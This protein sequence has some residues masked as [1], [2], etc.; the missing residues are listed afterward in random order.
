MKSN[1]WI[2]ILDYGSQYSQLIA[3]RVREQHVYSEM[4]RFD[5]DAATLAKRKPAGIILSG[6][7]S[8]VFQD[9]APMGDPKL[10]DIGVPV[11]GICYGMQMT[12]KILG[13]HVRPG[14]EREYGH[15][16]IARQGISSLF[17][18]LPDTINVWMSHGDQ[19]ERL[20]EGFRVA[21]STSTC[22]VAAMVSADDRIFGLQF[23]PEVAHTQH[24]ADILKRFVFDVCG[25]RGEW[26]MSQ[27]VEE[28]IRDIRAKVG[29]KHVIC[30]LS[31]GVDSSVV[32]LLLHKAIGDQLHCIFVDNGVLRHGE[33]EQVEDTF[34]SAF[35][36]DLHVAHA[37]D[38][39]LRK[40]KGVVDPETK[41]KIIGNTF[42]DVFSE[43]ARR[44]GDIDFLAQGT[45]YPDVIESLSPLGGP[46][47][48]IK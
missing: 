28:S 45:L 30:G 11:L 17:E 24:G 4:M 14:A 34:G 31:G 27:F 25:C 3:R 9:G 47:V 36:L 40:L 6:G 35:G 48:T 21:A 23:H 46:S 44:L 12:A 38:L 26:Q 43:E 1:D 22:P 5:T 37:A 41:R 15:A 29:K 42:I 32:A 7:P 13:G 39:F 8:S 20:P 16:R 33:A 18:G 2:A 19:V 10:F